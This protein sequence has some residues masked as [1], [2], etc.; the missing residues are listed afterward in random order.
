MF[1]SMIEHQVPSVYASAHG[2]HHN[3]N[4]KESYVSSKA[5]SLKA[6]NKILANSLSGEDSSNFQDLVGEETA[7]AKLLRR[8]KEVVKKMYALLLKSWRRT[9]L[10]YQ[11]VRDTSSSSKS[12]NSRLSHLDNKDR[13]L[14]KT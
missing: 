7:K 4:S 3:L 13:T 8:L 10:L 1:V 14:R 9:H 11:L 5:A 12:R 6:I 2:G